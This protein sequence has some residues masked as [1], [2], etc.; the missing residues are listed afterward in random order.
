MDRLDKFTWVFVLLLGG[1]IACAPSPEHS[2]QAGECPPLEAPSG[3]VG[4]VSIRED[5][6]DPLGIETEPVVALDGP[7]TQRLA[8]IIEIPPGLGLTVTA[9]LAG[10]IHA[11]PEPALQALRVGERMTKGAEVFRLVPL[12]PVDRDLRAQARKQSATTEAR[13]NV[14]RARLERLETLMRSRASSERAVEEARGE[15]ET[16]QAE[17]RAAKARLRVI[18]RTPLT[19]DVSLPLLAPQAGRLRSISVAEGQTVSAGAPVFDMLPDEGLWVRVSVPPSRRDAIDPNAPARVSRLGSAGEEGIPAEPVR[20]PPSADPIAATIDL[21]YAL[22]PETAFRYPGERVVV[23]L[24][25]RQLTPS[26]SVPSSAVVFDVDGGA[27]VYTCDA[28]PRFH[29]VRVDVL[30][31]RGGRAILRRGPP[32][33]TCVV[34]VGA[35]ELLGAE[36]GVSH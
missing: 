27:W 30:A 12:A 22:P 7:L 4:G 31:H 24:S 8:G 9:P 10:T 29:R 26:T 20:A 28:S 33:G 25:S 15:L 1:P 13:V 35:L 14:A 11:G 2:A 21:V 23:T 17:D 32:V 18:D 36:F 3:E 5:D 34:R 19:A 16:A 6:I